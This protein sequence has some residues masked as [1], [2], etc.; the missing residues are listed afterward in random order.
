MS[1]N[2]FSTI[3]QKHLIW[4]LLRFLKSTSTLFWVDLPFWEY[5]LRLIVFGLWN[6][7]TSLSLPLPHTHMDS[8]T[9]GIW[10]L[11]HCLVPE[12]NGLRVDQIVCCTSS[13]QQRTFFYFSYL[14]FQFWDLAIRFKNF[15]F[16]T[17]V[18]PS[19]LMWKKYRIRGHDHILLRVM[20]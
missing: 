4:T 5:Y 10:M 13:R 17:I 11:V 19:F 16:C 14:C 20:I 3:L 8:Y 2:T 1:I 12:V 15:G 18:E 7:W 6:K 9:L